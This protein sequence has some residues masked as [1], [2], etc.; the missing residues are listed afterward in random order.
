MGLAQH[1]HFE[2]LL[3]RTALSA[4]LKTSSPNCSTYAWPATLSVT[5][6]FSEFSSLN[7]RL[8]CQLV[9]TLVFSSNI[10]RGT[11]YSF[12]LVHQ[13]RCE[14][15]GFFGGI[16][17]T[18]GDNLVNDPIIACYDGWFC[19]VSLGSSRVSWQDTNTNMRSPVLR[20]R[21]ARRG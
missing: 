1:T 6:S 11:A 14:L 4:L 2:A 15:G 8:Q 7:L 13:S 3:A 16:V 18:L 21:F 19:R 20:V 5:A 17:K 9:L 10:P 12:Q